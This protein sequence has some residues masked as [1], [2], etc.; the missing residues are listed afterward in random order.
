MTDNHPPVLGAAMSEKTEKRTPLCVAPFVSQAIW[1][2]GE[3][4][5]CCEDKG[6][7]AGHLAL[8]DDMS[9]LV[10]SEKMRNAR[11]QFMRGEVPEGCRVCLDESTRQPTVYHYY[12]EHF[13]WDEAAGAYD[14]TTGSVGQTRYLLIALSL[15]LSLAE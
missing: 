3:S 2:D 7:P 9:E 11:Q 13:R 12:K 14:E 15:G 5:I 10:N 4:V 1:A 6:P 8:V